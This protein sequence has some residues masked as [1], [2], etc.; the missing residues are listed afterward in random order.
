[1]EY[2]GGGDRAIEEEPAAATEAVA[3]GTTGA[4]GGDL[5]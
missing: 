3:V 1:V 4:E 2:D 5:E